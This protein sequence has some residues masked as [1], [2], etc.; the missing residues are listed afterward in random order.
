MTG[1]EEPDFRIVLVGK[2]G[3]G[4]SATGNTILRK[5]VF[6][7]ELSAASVTSECQKETGEFE[8]KTLEV[9]DTPGLFDP[10]KSQE[11]VTK[12]IVKSMSMAAPGPHVFLVVIQLG[13]FTKEEEET[14]KIIQNVFGEEA[15][16]YTIVL[17][18]RGD[19]LEAD[20]VSTEKVIGKN[21]A[22]QDFLSQCHGGYH[23]FNNRD[24]DPSQVRELL[25]KINT[26]VERNGGS[27]YTNETLQEAERAI[28]EEMRCL[29]K[30]YP[31]LTFK[32][33]RRRAEKDN[34]FTERVLAG[35][36]GVLG[37]AGGAA[38]G[39]AAGVAVEVAVGAEIGAAV[40]LVGGPVGAA[41]GVLVG[42]A[43]IGIAAAVKKARAKQ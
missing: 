34:K 31:D 41:V 15:A 33:A 20:G 25:E 24:K 30:K 22:L 32:E 38:G 12:E 26:M 21:K 40:G 9:V 1:C 35:V 13:R 14:V 29:K 23:V 3:A 5:K 16:R 17:F 42:A 27:C 19:D 8:G 10:N 11:K 2:T 28:K 39:A 6:Q 37:V 4:K 7:S 18:T 36:F 43:V